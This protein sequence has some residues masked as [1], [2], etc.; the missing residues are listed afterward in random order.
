MIFFAVKGGD[1]IKTKIFWWQVAGFIFVSAFGTLLHFLYEW[2]NCKFCA[3]FSGVNEST[4][5]HMK[6][7]FFPMLLF[8][9]VQSPFFSANIENFFS[10][11]L[12][13]VL[14]GLLTIPCIFY[15]LQGCFGKTPDWINIGIFFLS[16]A[17][18]FIYEAT[19]FR[20]GSSSELADKLAVGGLCIIAFLF[21]VF[22]FY[23]P[24]LPLFLDPIT[25]NY[26]I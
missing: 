26:G 7:L 19:H 8:T 16:A 4:W 6:L 24:H 3:L 2:F 15:T 13:G 21:F 25:K 23:P 22:T 1:E 10:V 11:K 12:K 14:I 9:L 5:E 20:G 18:T 17:I